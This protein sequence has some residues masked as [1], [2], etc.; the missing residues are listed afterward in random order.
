[1]TRDKPAVV[2]YN[3][4]IWIHVQ[5]YIINTCCSGDLEKMSAGWAEW[6][7]RQDFSPLSLAVSTGS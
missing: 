7:F 2:T 3:A 6:H 1:M 5:L 4:S